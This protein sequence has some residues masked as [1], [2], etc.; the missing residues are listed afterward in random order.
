MK[1]FF[2]SFIF[3]SINIMAEPCN[4]ELFAKIY[5]LDK[6]QILFPKDIVKNNSC[7]EETLTK[8]SKLLS[9]VE[10]NDGF[11]ISKIE[12]EIG[13][14]FVH[15]TPRKLAIIDLS[16]ELRAQ[17]TPNS[18]L[19]F[20]DIRS[21]N[22]LNVLSLS[23]EES[24]KINCESCSTLG[25]KNIK[26]EI[27]NP[28][29]NSQKT[30]WM[31]SKIFAK[32]KVIKAKRSLS[33]QQKSL[34]PEDVYTDETLTMMTDNLLSTTEHIQFFKPN[35]TILQ[36]SILTNM[37][38]TPVNLVNYGVPVKATLKS[39]SI[40]LTKIVTPTRSAQFGE[41]VE[42]K[43]GNNKTISGKVIDYNQV[44]IEL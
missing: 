24:L 41:M 38:I 7:N 13:D 3:F 1:L 18:N 9:Q 23:E 22:K 40:G 35:R 36:G 20:L 42:L 2:F 26:I 27:L 15:I 4:V 29:A 37:D 21:M 19:Y 5:K 39:D 43:V 11:S 17:L 30:L 14:N 16:S 10:T 8:I 33:F 31:S 44:V 28:I 12:K 6:N 34:S 32:V 25:E